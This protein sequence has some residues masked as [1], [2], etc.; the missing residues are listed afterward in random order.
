MFYAFSDWYVRRLL[1]NLQW[2]LTFSERHL[3]DENSERVLTLGSTA[4]R[5]TWR[6]VKHA[7]GLHF[8]KLVIAHG[9]S[10]RR[11]SEK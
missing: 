3:W 5:G 4:R 8:V 1:F 11:I 9:N 10:P 2:P 7:R 6:V